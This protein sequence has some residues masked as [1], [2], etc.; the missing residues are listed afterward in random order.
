MTLSPEQ[1]AAIAKINNL[2]R[3]LEGA[4]HERKD[5]IDAMLT[6]L[7]ARQH[8]LLLGPPGT[9]KSMLGFLL[10]KAIGGTT[11]TRLMT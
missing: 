11:L 5:E 4:V 10:A 8:L 3:E 2:R 6:A 9:A 1:S 7:I